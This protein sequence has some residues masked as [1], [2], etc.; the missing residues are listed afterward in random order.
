MRYRVR[1]EQRMALLGQGELVIGRSPYCSLMLEHGSVSRIHA[2]LRHLGEEVEIEDLGSSNGT[3]VNGERITGARKLRPGD[4]L[5]IGALALVLEV[6]PTREALRTG[7][8]LSPSVDEEG[9][10]IVDTMVMGTGEKD[11]R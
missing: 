11:R 1:A 9:E 5:R 3:F 8:R 4:E 7:K 10:L 6:A 2:V